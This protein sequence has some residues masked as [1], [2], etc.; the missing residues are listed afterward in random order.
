M[1]KIWHRTPYNELPVTPEE[2]PALVTE[3][4]LN[5]RASRQHM[6]QFMFVAFTVPARYEA[7]QA[8]P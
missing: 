4:P 6:A 8:V 2:H 7:I 3:A 1:E 5:P